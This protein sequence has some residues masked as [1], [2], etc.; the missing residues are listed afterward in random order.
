MTTSAFFNIADVQIDVAR[1]LSLI[2]PNEFLF[3]TF[4]LAS[5]WNRPITSTK[6]AKELGCSEV[7]V[8]D[9]LNL[10]A[11]LHLFHKQ[12]QRY[13]LTD[14][15]K[16]LVLFIK[17]SIV[18]EQVADLMAMVSAP[19]DVSHNYFGIDSTMTEQNPHAMTT[20][21]RATDGRALPELE[22]EAESNL[23]IWDNTVAEN[24]T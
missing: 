19:E 18:T 13:A 6:L 16:F 5:D 20:E 24:A 1:T 10:L 4:Y 17:Q 22:P 3:T 21:Y 2:V 7:L 11:T 15:G 12:G 14:M 23:S 8:R 9:H